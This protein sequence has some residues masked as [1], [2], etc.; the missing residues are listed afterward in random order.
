MQLAIFNFQDCCVCMRT[1]MRISACER[2]M[3][4]SYSRPIEEAAL[5]LNRHGRNSARVLPALRSESTA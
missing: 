3:L 5:P 2:P 4:Y 1:A